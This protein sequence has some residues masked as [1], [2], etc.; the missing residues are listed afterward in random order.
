MLVAFA[1]LLSWPVVTVLLFRML[2]FRDAL[3]WTIVAG[4]L[5]LPSSGQV[6][7]DLPLLPP[8]DKW[9][10][11]P[12]SAA[13]VALILLTRRTASRRRDQRQGKTDNLSD[14]VVLKGWVPRSGV[15]LLLFVAI[16]AGIFGTAL[17][18]GDPVSSGARSMPSLSLYDAAA[19]LLVTGV[20]FLP[21]LLGRKF[22]SDDKSHERLL[23]ILF[24]SALIYTLPALYEVRMS[25]QINRTVYGFFPHSW[26]QHIR[27][28][29]FR[30]LVFL[31]HGLLL[32]IHFACALIAGTILFRLRQSGERLLLAVA[33]LWLLFAL[34]L[35]KTLG[36]FLIALVLMPVALLLGTR[37]H[38]LV[39]AV[40]AGLTLS[41][42]ILRGADLIPT[43]QLVQTA[44]AIDSDRAGS[45]QFR[46]DNEDLLLGRANERP[47]FGWGWWARSRIFNDRGEDD[48]V[49][50]GSWIIIIG[51]TGWFGYIGQFGLLTIPI[52]LFFLRRKRYKVTL[53]TS[54]L[55]LVL[56]ANL[57]DLLP[58]SSLVPVLYLTAGA[59]LG[60]L[61]QTKSAAADEADAHPASDSPEVSRVAPAQ[62]AVEADLQHT[63]YSRFRVRKREAG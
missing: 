9:L 33:I 7:V 1:V 62:A 2:P 50:D 53:V 58:N 15:A 10:V 24:I 23:W 4:F 39:A 42:P 21:L 45:L 54:G 11:P 26:I 13:L 55:C 56:A 49:T 41:Y 27:G 37:T 12:V 51:Q 30:P 20:F 34:L 35:S 47:V 52:M 60:R 17:T 36:A 61:E 57:I 29:G 28:G 6:S 3:I 18:N 48:V 40:I 43:D 25:P 59:L 5:F 19:N 31:D 8:L 14:V 16:G 44:A 63:R 22:L 38:L 32:G 46:F